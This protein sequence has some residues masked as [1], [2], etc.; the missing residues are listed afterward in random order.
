MRAVAEGLGACYDTGVVYLDNP[1]AQAAKMRRITE[2]GHQSPMSVPP[3]QRRWITEYIA[4][5]IRKGGARHVSKAIRDSVFLLRDWL[6]SRLTSGRLGVQSPV[7]A[8]IKRWLI[9]HGRISRRYGYPP[10]LGIRTGNLLR[11]I[12]AKMEKRHV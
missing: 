7:T 5:A 11:S 3:S 6:K 12:Q 9:D 8:K 4:A 10:P 2:Y 1:R